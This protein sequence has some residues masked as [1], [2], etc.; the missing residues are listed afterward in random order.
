[1]IKTSI[2]Q[3]FAEPTNINYVINETV[4]ESFGGT[5]SADVLDFFDFGQQNKKRN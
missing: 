5:C 4:I 1:M 2:N 3:N